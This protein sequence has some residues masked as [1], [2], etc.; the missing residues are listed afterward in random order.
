MH[1]TWRSG[2]LETV[3]DPAGNPNAGIPT[4]KTVH[5]SP[6]YK[7]P[8]LSRS[9]PVSLPSPSGQARRSFTVT[10]PPSGTGTFLSRSVEHACHRERSRACSSQPGSVPN[11]RTSRFLLSGF[12]YQ[13]PGRHMAS[14]WIP[15]RNCSRH[16]SRRD[17]VFGIGRDTVLVQV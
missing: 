2:S 17:H 1:A 9:G 5:A 10:S 7:A 3:S 12:R 4:Y 16:T 14:H 13:S 11:A 15:V 6:P 8:R